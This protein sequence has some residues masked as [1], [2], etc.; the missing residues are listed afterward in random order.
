MIRD[1]GE[2]ERP[3]DRDFIG[4][5]AVGALIMVAWSKLAPLGR[6]APSGEGGLSPNV[7]RAIV[8]GAVLVASLGVVSFV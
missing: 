2:V 8:A 6:I 1:G 4:G 3:V 7:A 5:L